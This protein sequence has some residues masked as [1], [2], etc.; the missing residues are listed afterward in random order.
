M[1]R[2]SKFYTL[3]LGSFLY[4]TQISIKEVFKTVYS[5]IYLSLVVLGLHWWIRAVSSCCE[6]GATL[7]C[8]SVE[9]WHV[10]TS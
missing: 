10:E 4:V 1:L 7:C 5:S 9:I 3:N 8:G 2:V 6:Q